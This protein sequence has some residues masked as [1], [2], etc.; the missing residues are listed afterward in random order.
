VFLKPFGDKSDTVVVNQLPIYHGGEKVNPMKIAQIS[1]P[2]TRT[3]P[4]NYGGVEVVVSCLTE[5]LVSLGH[6]VTLFAAGN[7][8]TSAKLWSTDEK[9]SVQGFSITDEILHVV[10]SYE[11]IAQSDFDIIHNHTYTVG[12]AV[13]SL[14]NL[15]SVSTHHCTRSLRQWYYHSAFANHR[16]ISISHNQQKTMPGLNWVANVYNAINVGDFTFQAEKDDYLLFIGNIVPPKGTHIAVQVAKKLGRKLKLAGPYSTDYFERE[17]APYID[18]QLIEYVG[19]VNFAQKVSL[20]KH[21]SALLMPIQW[22]G[23]LD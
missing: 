9:P 3:P 14:S 2:W 11:Y 18:N 21:A 15:P 17:I 20:Y 7:S 16:Y 12:Q 4:E 8:I 5:N 23:H 13:L 19:I 1:T 10:K 22:E 6:D